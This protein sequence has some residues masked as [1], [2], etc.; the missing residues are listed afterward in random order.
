MHRT[1]TRDEIAHVM[2]T[3]TPYRV[4]VRHGCVVVWHDRWNG[5]VIRPGRFP[6]VKPTIPDPKCLLGYTI[7]CFLTAGVALLAW[8]ALSEASR[9][10][11][12]E[13]R[14]V[15]KKDLGILTQ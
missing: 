11:T 9:E 8:L 5:A 15:F 14:K 7:A 1:L 12:A 6:T 10:V 3:R 2:R 13:I 4:T